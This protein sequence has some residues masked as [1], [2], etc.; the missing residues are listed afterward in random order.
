AIYTVHGFHFYKGAPKLNN[1][2]YKNVEKYLA[3]LTTSIITITKEDYESALEF[4]KVNRE[5]SVFY[6]PGVGINTNEIIGTKPNRNKLCQE[7]GVNNESFLII[8]AGE[9]NKNKNQKIIIEA[10]SDIEKN[11]DI[12][13]I[14]CGIGPMENEL[15]KLAFEKG[16]DK[17]IHFLG[18][19]KDIVEL[20][21]SSDVFVMPSY[22]EGLSRSMMEAMAAGLPCIASKIRGNVD[23]IENGQGGYLC[24][25]NDVDSFS[26]AIKILSDDVKLRKSMSK[27]NLDRIKDYDVENIITEIDKI[28]NE[29]LA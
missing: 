13:Y 6:V 2:I 12:H 27:Y 15:R 25:S 8:S 19:R 22:R 23:L 7:L 28:Y 16:I 11:K 4:K 26:K 14:I 18:Y 17:N 9:L 20:M 10:I 1:I 24:D 5:L 21:K 29:E 3:K